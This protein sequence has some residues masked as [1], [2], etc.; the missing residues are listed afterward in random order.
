MVHAKGAYLYLDG[1]NFNAFVGKVK[2]AEMG[3]DVMHMNLHKTFSTP[4]GGGGPG[5]GPVGVVDALVPFLPVPTVER[6][7]SGF[8]LDHDRPQSIGKMRTFYGNFGVLVRALAYV[9]SYG[10]SI[11]EVAEVA[12]L[13]ANYIRKRL[14]PYYHLEYSAPSYHEVV[15]DDTKQAAA[16]IHNIDIAKRLMDYGFHPPTM[17]FPLIVHGALMIEPT[18]TE[19]KEELDAFADAMISIAKEC[20]ER[21]DLVKTAPHTTPVGRLDEASLAR[22]ASKA[23]NFAPVLRAKVD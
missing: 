2:P 7:G 5:A 10:R 3:V 4:H 15:F 21:P 17:S 13:N 1:A 23:G 9:L 14:E 19:P 8:R 6:A 22:E 18:E 11:T 20:E 12:V 16:G